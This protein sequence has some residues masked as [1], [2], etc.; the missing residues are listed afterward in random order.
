[1]AW[2][3]LDLR[4]LGGVSR[5]FALPPPGD[6][7]LDVQ[8]YTH[9]KRVIEASLVDDSGHF[10][11]SSGLFRLDGIS[12]PVDAPGFFH[13]GKYAAPFSLFRDIHPYGFETDI[14]Y[15]A[16]YSRGNFS[17]QEERFNGHL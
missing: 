10:F 3:G 16:A 8:E 4:I 2:R 12:R 11:V 9:P 7:A 14:F 15:R 1:M 6:G 5:N 13:D 17:I